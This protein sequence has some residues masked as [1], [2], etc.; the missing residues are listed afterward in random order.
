MRSLQAEIRRKTKGVTPVIAT[1][2]LIS[3]TVVLSLVV[4]AYTFG[5]FGSNVKTIVIMSATFYGGP[6]PY[7]RYCNVNQAPYMVLSISNPGATTNITSLTVTSSSLTVIVSSD[8]EDPKSGGCNSI[9]FPAPND[10]PIIAAG[11]VSQIIVYFNGPLCT[12]VNQ[13]NICLLAPQT[14]SIATGQT[15]NYVV[16]FQSGQ[17]ISGSI[18]AQ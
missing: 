6:L 7:F 14:G 5:L 18:I 2:L 12:L 3:G 4:G 17:S 16:N 1:I 13:L 11:S 9:G 8:Y 15:F 10:G